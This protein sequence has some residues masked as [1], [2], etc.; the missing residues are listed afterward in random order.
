ME[1]KSETSS[2][3]SWNVIIVGS[4]GVGKTSLYN[5]LTGEN[6]P[7]S[8][9]GEDCTLNCTQSTMS[10]AKVKITDTPGLSD[11]M[12][13][14][15]WWSD[16]AKHSSVR[17][18]LLLFNGTTVR[19]S[20]MAKLLS[21]AHFLK[22]I[23]A[24]RIFLIPTFRSLIT[25]SLCYLSMDMIIRILIWNT[26][27]YLKKSKHL[28]KISIYNDFNENHPQVAKEYALRVIFLI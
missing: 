18:T 12:D 4:P 11:A 20:N 7:T 16:L 26:I 21:I 2:N 9:K 5:Y 14:L 22:V 3:Q 28:I 6:E 27:I 1:V 13:D 8:K 10:G 19:N 17:L 25:I 23:S 15:T 24:Y